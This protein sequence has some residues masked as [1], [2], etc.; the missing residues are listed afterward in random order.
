MTAQI[1]YFSGTGNSLKV[2][3]DLAERLPEAR[4]TA[5]PVALESKPGEPADSV[6]L[7]FPVYFG[8]LPLVVERF[9]RRLPAADYV[10]AVATHGGMPGNALRQLERVLAAKG[11]ELS[12]GFA[13]QMPGN[14]TKLY[15]AR[16]RKAQSRFFAQAADQVEEIARKVAA[17][18]TH[19]PETGF[20]LATW[21]FA[22][23][24]R[25]HFARKAH[26]KDSDF[27]ADEKCTSCGICAKVCPVE[28]IRLEDGRP[29][30]LHHCE[31]CY[32]C[33]QWCPEEAIQASRK[34]PDRKRY[35]HP[36]I[37]VTDMFLR[38]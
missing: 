27:W 17:R 32:A 33:L 36:D 19:P 9:A 26:G 2:A 10:F 16:S 25:L 21:S 37:R 28:N 8:G 14:Y 35:H 38:E 24:Y 13:V 12:A 18:E 4:M 29:T 23:L 7:V 15:G 1:Y 31:Q 30:W 22:I 6:G 11:T 5:V 34:T 3:R 20:F